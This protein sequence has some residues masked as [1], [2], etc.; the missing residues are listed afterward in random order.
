[1]TNIIP[2]PKFTS[3]PVT[4]KEA[5]AQ[6]DEV[7]R[8]KADGMADLIMEEFFSCTSVGGFDFEEDPD[9][10]KDLTLIMH[11]V[12]SILYKRMGLLHPLQ[13]MAEET[14]DV[15]DEGIISFKKDP[16]EVQETV[17]VAR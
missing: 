14:F 4:M 8:Y 15:S 2:F 10:D 12:T 5:D 16:E 11:A 13:K 17:D 1:M 7:R 6:L 3:V 9:Y